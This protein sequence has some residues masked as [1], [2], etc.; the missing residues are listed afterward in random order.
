MKRAIVIA[1]LLLAGCE[2]A[3]NPYPNGPGFYETKI[4]QNRYRITYRAVGRMPRDR[5]ETFT[6]LRAADLTLGE[7]YDWF[8]IVGRSGSVDQK[9]GPTL[10]LGTGSTSFGR[11]S[12][13]GLGIGTS[14]DLSGPPAQ[15]LTLEVVMGKG[16]RPDDQEA[17]DAADVA[18]T[19]RSQL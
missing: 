12:A 8:R 13:V 17:Y 14:F 9:N 10:S 15:A 16:A 1:A 11:H 3:P 6:L 19:L 7:G 5:V 18:K 4:E 2:T